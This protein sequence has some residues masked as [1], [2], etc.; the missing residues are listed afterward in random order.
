[1]NAFESYLLNEYQLPSNVCCNKFTYTHSTKRKVD[2][3]SKIPLINNVI[4]VRVESYDDKHNLISTHT[5]KFIDGCI[6]RSKQKKLINISPDELNNRFGAAK[7]NIV[8][9]INAE[10]SVKLNE[11]QEKINELNSYCK[12]NGVIPN[13]FVNEPKIADK[14]NIENV[15]SSNKIK[16]FEF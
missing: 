15:K 9:Q 7:V 3:S 8:Q 13:R 6:N 5:E 10:Y 4:N 14:P 16:R 1:M 12:S 11:I 2:K